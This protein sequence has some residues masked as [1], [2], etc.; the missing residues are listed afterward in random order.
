MATAP[1]DALPTCPSVTGVQVVPP[2][3]V[4]KRP[5]PVAPK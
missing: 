1:T 4:L 2:S 5:P 3:L